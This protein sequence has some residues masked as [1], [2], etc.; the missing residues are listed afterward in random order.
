M[1][2][3]KYTEIKDQILT[4]PTH[5][6]KE[7]VKD[8]LHSIVKNSHDNISY[9]YVKNIACPHCKSTSKVK[10]GMLKNRQR[11][12][13]K[14]CRKSY[15]TFTKTPISYSK[16]EITKWEKYIDMLLSCISLRKISKELDISLSTAFYWRHKL[17]D[18]LKENNITRNKFKNSVK[19]YEFYTR[20][21]FKGSH[22]PRKRK[23]YKSGENPG[24][25]FIGDDDV[26]VMIAA[27]GTNPPLIEMACLNKPKDDTL[28]AIFDGAI[29][30][31]S[32]IITDKWMPYKRLAQKNNLIYVPYLNRYHK[33]RAY[34]IKEIEN[35]TMK[36][37]NFLDH[38][39]GVATKYLD[40]YLSLFKKLY[41]VTC[42]IDYNLHVDSKIR[43]RDYKFREASY[44]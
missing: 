40:N 7:I 1:N 30:S 36:L 34:H 10:N 11:Y 33:S 20:E 9:E 32:A 28:N 38:Y 29:E 5:Q 39:Q 25:K 31:G 22:V 44:R 2:S 43:V 19:I 27:D 35:I 42:H 17:L 18:A 24:Y 12:L 13:C 21:S 37:S 15:N 16:K 23:A 3:N 4:L 41:Y 14:T 26:C 8:L 6:R